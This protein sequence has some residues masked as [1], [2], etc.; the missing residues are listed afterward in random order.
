[1]KKGLL[2]SWLKRARKAKGFTAKELAEQAGVSLN[3]IQRIEGGSRALSASSQEKIETALG[4]TREEFP[5]NFEDILAKL[6]TLIQENSEHTTCYIS[7]SF[8]CGN[9]I[10]LDVQESPSNSNC[11]AIDALLA[12]YLIEFQMWALS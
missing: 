2:V 11:F 10:F 4:F 7:Y 3:L 8:V 9:I 1:M 12:K 5:L 6:D